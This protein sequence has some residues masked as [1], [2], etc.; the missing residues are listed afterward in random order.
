[1][2]PRPY[3]L[4]EANHRQLTADRPNVAVLPWGATEAHNWHLPYGTDVIEATGI[5]Y[6]SARLAHEAGAKVVVLPTIP[7]GNDEQQLDQVATISITT[8]TALALLRDVARSLTRQ[9]IDRLV[10]V[11]AHGGNQFQGLVRDIQGEFGLLVV[12]INFWQIRPEL[13]DEVFDQPGDHAG[14]LETS[15][16]LH[17]TADLVEMEHA[18]SGERRPFAIEALRQPG[19]WTPRPWGQVHPDT[20]CGDPAGAT[21]EK[22]ARYFAGITQAVADVLV[23]LARAQKGDI[24][25]V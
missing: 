24:P 10:L 12:V 19:V 22:G 3:V 17:L 16:L 25:Y 13:I 9:G 20:G 2:P 4:M 11:N 21:A 8:S 14:E 5:A 7:F 23:G 15:L 1:M 18:G 6:E